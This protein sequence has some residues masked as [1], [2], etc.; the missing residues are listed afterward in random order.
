M[1]MVRCLF[2]VACTP[3]ELM[4]PLRRKL[5]EEMENQ[6]ARIEGG[7]WRA[8]FLGERSASSG[9]IEFVAC[10][11]RTK[12]DKLR[13][14]LPRAIEAHNP[15]YIVR[16]DDDDLINPAIMDIINDHAEFDCL[17]DRK[18]W[19]FDIVTGQLSNES[20]DWFA[21]T[22]VQKTEHAMATI[23][24][25]EGD[26]PVIAGDHSKEWHR[27]FADKQVKYTEEKRPL[28]IRTLSPTSI[29]AGNANSEDWKAYAQY[30][31]GFGDWSAKVPNGF[32]FAV[33]N[34]REFGQSRFKDVDPSLFKTPGKW[35]KLL[36][37][38]LK[39]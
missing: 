19:F 3:D 28:Y 4:T 13:A 7:R 6:L 5:R 21:N 34:L 23:P 14:W 37:R 24:W 12:G 29:T 16:L 10:N 33:E 11:E 38:I 31:N 20:R 1:S 22:V 15:D 39:R 32:S 36:D 25:V 18:H 17:V 2:I 26:V 35:K 9:P 30:R 27:Y 8:W